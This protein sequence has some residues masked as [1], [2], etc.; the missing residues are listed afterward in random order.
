MAPSFVGTIDHRGY[1]PERRTL[2]W[3]RGTE[4]AGET[5][6]D[7]TIPR[8]GGPNVARWRNNRTDLAGAIA[9][10]WLGVEHMG[11]EGPRVLTKLFQIFGIMRDPT[12]E[13]MQEFCFC[14]V[15]EKY[16]DGMHIPA[17]QRILGD[18]TWG[19]DRLEAMK[20]GAGNNPWFVGIPGEQQYMA[21][22]RS[23]VW[24]INT[25]NP[26]TGKFKPGEEP[27][28][29][30]P[31]FQ[32]G[33]VQP[34]PGEVPDEPKPEPDDVETHLGEIKNQAKAARKLLRD[35]G[36]QEKGGGAYARELRD[37]LKVIGVMLILALSLAGCGTLGAVKPPVLPGHANGPLKQLWMALISRATLGDEVFEGASVESI[38]SGDVA[39]GLVTDAI[40]S[41]FGDL[42]P[43]VG[44]LVG[45]RLIEKAGPRAWSVKVV[46]DPA[47]APPRWF[48]VRQS[49]GAGK[50]AALLPNTPVKIYAKRYEVPGFSALIVTRWAEK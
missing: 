50:V 1:T 46:G 44:E 14:N 45:Q 33:D 15:P 21:Y 8:D 17:A 40:Q 7:P 5:T 31:P 27:E 13:E 34:L 25:R 24:Y 6:L 18:P 35:K 9:E 38:D 26:E 36:T 30:L 19:A 23:G 41:R 42:A 49:A 10:C 20:K 29:T 11:G 16:Y 12:R 4:Y 37:L 32:P 43:L 2:H 39:A 22:I 28:K 3:M 47:D 48:F